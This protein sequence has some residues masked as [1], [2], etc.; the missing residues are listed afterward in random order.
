MFFSFGGKAPF[1]EGGF[2]GPEFLFGLARSGAGSR[3][4]RGIRIGVPGDARAMRCGYFDYTSAGRRLQ[5]ARVGFAA[6]A[7]CFSLRRVRGIT[8]ASDAPERVLVSER[9][10]C[11]P[12]GAGRKTPG[13]SSQGVP[14][15]FIICGDIRF[16]AA[17]SERRARTFFPATKCPEPP[18]VSPSHRVGRA[19][20]RKN[21]GIPPGVGHTCS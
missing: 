17:A 9:G 21:P 11:A 8:P 15:M 13:F 3:I 5:A 20:G 1:P 7:E 16:A 14:R 10:S 12:Y 18:R 6:R 4:N 19:A 2:P